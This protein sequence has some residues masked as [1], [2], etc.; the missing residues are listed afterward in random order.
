M[1]KS[2][3]F[4]WTTEADTAFAELKTLLSTQLV[5]AVPISKGLYCF[6]LQPLDKLSV[7]YSRSSGKKK[8]KP[9]RF[10]AQCT[11]FLKS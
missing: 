1:K 4:E 10:S 6:T 11:I 3:K 9:T 2:D 8:V 7:Q 5:L